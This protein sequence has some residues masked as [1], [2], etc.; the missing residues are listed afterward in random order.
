MCGSAPSI[1]GPDA[2]MDGDRGRGPVT[3]AGLWRS[4]ILDPGLRH[5][6][7]WYQAGS[8]PLLRYLEGTSEGLIALD[9]LWFLDLT[10]LTS[11]CVRDG[12]C[13]TVFVWTKIVPSGSGPAGR[14]GA[15]TVY[16]DGS[17]RLFVLG[18]AVV[19]GEEVSAYGPAMPSLTEEVA[20]TW[21]IDLVGS[22]AICL[23]AY[24]YMFPVLKLCLVLCYL[25]MRV[26]CTETACGATRKRPRHGHA[27][28]Q[29]AFPL[30]QNDG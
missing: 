8:S 4:Y 14:F 24:Y 29:V 16:D 1:D 11:E 13:G 7:R 15:G 22:Y 6:A 23:R 18:G 26:G 21:T 25:P 5:S 17:G 2:D 9:D 30:V 20:E 3:A 27:G 10:E 19:R 28:L 12:V